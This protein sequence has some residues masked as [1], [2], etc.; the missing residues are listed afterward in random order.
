MEN[1]FYKYTPSA[2]WSEYTFIFASVSVGNIA[3]LGVDLLITSLSNTHK[4]GYLISQLVQPIVGHDP[5]V[6]NSTDISLSCE[7][8]ENKALKLVIFQQR[9]PLFKGK[10]NEFVQF[11]ADFIERER[12]AET[13]CLTSSY[14]WERLDSQLT[15]IQCR[16]LAA[17]NTNKAVAHLQQTLKWKVLENRP[18]HDKDQNQSLVGYIP[19]GGIAQKFYKISQ[20]K[21]LNAY[22]LIVFAHE[23][24]NIPEAIELV[25]YLNQWKEYLNKSTASSWRIPISWKYLFGQSID[26]TIQSLM[27]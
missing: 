7:L 23:G 8:Y 11:L 21:N 15:G 18:E 27:F 9:A 12:F 24:N 14:G 10:R 1:M 5:Y 26:P 3:Q 25:N 22:V 19:G 2:D 17:Q 13:I 4:A 20:E 6:Q 16:F